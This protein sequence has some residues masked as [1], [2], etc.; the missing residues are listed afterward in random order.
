MGKL[1]P[2]PVD[3]YQKANWSDLQILLNLNFK[4]KLIK[5][6]KVTIEFDSYDIPSEELINE[7]NNAG[8]TI[9]TSADGKSL[10]IT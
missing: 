8:Y 1:S 4:N 5:S 2:K 9:N 7:L 3:V 6:P 10:I